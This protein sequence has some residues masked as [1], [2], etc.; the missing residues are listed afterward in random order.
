M[1][2]ARKEMTDC[3]DNMKGNS[4]ELGDGLAKR[5]RLLRIGNVKDD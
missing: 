2:A 5:V 1:L 4:A 3:K